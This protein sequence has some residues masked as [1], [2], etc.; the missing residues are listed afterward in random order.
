MINYTVYPVDDEG[1]VISTYKGEE[2]RSNFFNK[3]SSHI[4][5][6]LQQE[7]G[8]K[9]L[10]GDWTYVVKEKRKG[11][12][13]FY[14]VYKNQYEHPDHVRNDADVTISD[15]DD[16]DIQD[17]L[18]HK[19]PKKITKKVREEPKPKPTTEPEP[20]VFPEN[21]DI[22]LITAVMTI[23]MRLFKNYVSIM[24]IKKN[25]TISIPPMYELIKAINEYS[26]LGIKRGDH[27]VSVRDVFG[28]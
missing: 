16:E 2:V 27:S 8:Y 23:P 13:I 9:D 11:D 7:D 14:V 26:I 22:E 19:T 12:H 10:I 3:I 25:P 17:E 5:D 21:S 4:Q 20:V 15:S 24:I 1:F 28:E 6:Q 18:F